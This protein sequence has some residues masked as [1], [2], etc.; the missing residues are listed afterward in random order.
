MAF[1]S[2][3]IRAGPRRPQIRRKTPIKGI[4]VALVLLTLAF[5]YRAPAVEIKAAADAA[6]PRCAS[7]LAKLPYTVAGLNRQETTGRSTAVWG[8]ALRDSA[9]LRRSRTRAHNANVRHRQRD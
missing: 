8:D 7:L 4:A 3:E 9:P 1:T 5:T 2:R 6:D